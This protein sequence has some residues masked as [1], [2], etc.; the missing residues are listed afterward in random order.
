MFGDGGNDELWGGDGT[1][2]DDGADDKLSG[3]GGSDS[4]RFGD[5]WGHDTIIDE[6]IPDNNPNT[7]NEVNFT[8]TSNSPLTVNLISLEATPEVSEGTN[9][10]NWDGNIIDN[11]YNPHTSS[12]TITGNNRANEI[13]SIASFD[14]D[15]V[16]SAGGDDFIN[17]QDGPGIDNVDC[18]E[19]N[20]T[21]IRD[22][23]DIVNNC[24]I[25][26]P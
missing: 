5:G 21:V 2:N 1:T 12:D 10:I 17:V 11:V 19:G 22:P 18:G 13:I 9:T 20:D 6:R 23:G 26:N 3:G 8:S 4:Y 14:N 16:S 15:T 25:E 24:E 7:G